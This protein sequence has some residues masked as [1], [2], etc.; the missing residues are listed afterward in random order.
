MKKSLLIYWPKGGN[1]DR[2]AHRI[3]SSFGGVTLQ[4]VSDVD[5]STL[6]GYDL[7]ILGGSTVGAENWEEAVESNAWGPFFHTMEKQGLRLDHTYVAFFGLG[8]HVLY[9]D[10]FVDG[11]GLL[12]EEFSKFGARLIGRW[13]AKGY[14]FTGSLGLDGDMFVGLALDEDHQP[15]LTGGRIDAW[16]AGLKQEMGG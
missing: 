9:P 7:I 6:A 13:P 3:A 11:L 16:V 12:Y 1:V 5:I 15:E 4:L 2:A 10:H 14:D 8:D